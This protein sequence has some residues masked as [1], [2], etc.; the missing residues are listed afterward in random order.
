MKAH[1]SGG[2]RPSAIAGTWYPGKSDQLA[3]QIDLML[4]H[5]P[6]IAAPGK[7]RALIV[8]HAGYRYSGNI[9]ARAFKAIQSMTYQRVVAISPIHHPYSDPLLTTS[10]SAYSTPL[11][12]IPVDWQVLEALSEQVPLSAVSNDPEHALEI[13]LPFLQRAL[14]A[15]FDFVPL[16]MRDQSYEAAERIARTLVDI[17][18]DGK[19]TLLV[20]S[21]DLSHFYSDTAARHFDRHLLELIA[22]NDAG[23]VIHAETQGIA[24]ACGRGA[25]AAV[26]LA[27]SWVG[28]KAVCITGY[29]TS[30]DAC[31]DYQ[32]VVGYGSAIICH[33]ANK[34]QVGLDA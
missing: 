13:E 12:I 29:S 31:G 19:D 21:S 7:I 9:A 11:G 32:R 20:A 17:F 24:F 5:A 22:A 27:S 18:Q 4:A 16:M 3:S 2:I 33:S 25:I 15:P 14:D 28:A 10:H 1:I 30:A 34:V 26:M 23:G 6:P 8:P